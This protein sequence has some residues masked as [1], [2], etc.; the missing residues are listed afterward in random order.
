MRY[1]RA[2]GLLQPAVQRV[3]V[4]AQLHLV[5]EEDAA[6]L[7]A[8]VDGRDELLS[9]CSSTSSSAVG[10]DAGR[11]R[12]VVA[13]GRGDEQARAAAGVTV[14]WL[15]CWPAPV[16]ETA[17]LPLG[18]RGG[19]R[20]AGALSPAQSPGCSLREVFK[21]KCGSPPPTPP[22]PSGIVHWWRLRT[23][24]WA[25]GGAGVVAGVVGRPPAWRGPLP[26]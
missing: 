23:H 14:G 22:A 13:A 16:G 12:W 18:E 20:G 19:A 24:Q 4:F 25:R 17:Q 5:E 6:R 10:H 26:L 15:A 1:K 2:R 21:Q 9:P 11:V 7:G 3:A 8:R